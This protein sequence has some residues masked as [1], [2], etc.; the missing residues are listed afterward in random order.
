MKKWII[1]AGLSAVGVLL[2]VIASVLAGRFDRWE[3]VEAQA[4]GVA[5]GQFNG[6]EQEM[7]HW[8]FLWLLVASCVVGV[9]TFV[10][11]AL[12][13]WRSRLLARASYS[14][15]F[16]WFGMTPVIAFLVIFPTWAVCGEAMECLKQ[17]K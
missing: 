3:I 7:L 2:F 16:F 5:V 11:A 12:V 8:A 9:A 14:S 15:L 6:A 17:M 13:K 10:I 1:A 4:Q